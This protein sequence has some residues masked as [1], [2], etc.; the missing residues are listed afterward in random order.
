M[1]HYREIRLYT[2]ENQLEVV[3]LSYMLFRQ[4]HFLVDV[5]QEQV[6]RPSLWCYLNYQ[7][8]PFTL[9]AGPIQ[10]YQEFEVYWADPAPL[11]TERHELLKSYLRIFFWCKHLQIYKGG[12]APGSGS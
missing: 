11:F 3:G 2:V 7:L 4:I 8:N 1:L 12:V 9:L 5:M 10:R 6:G